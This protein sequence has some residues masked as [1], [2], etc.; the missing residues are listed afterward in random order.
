MRRLIA[1][2]TRKNDLVVDPCAGGYGVL[3]ACQELGREFLG[4][5][6]IP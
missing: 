1:S 3:D 4:S 5:D 6:L 2:V